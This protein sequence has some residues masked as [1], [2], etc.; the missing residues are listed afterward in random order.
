MIKLQTFGS[1]WGLP[2]PSPFVTKADV[3]LKMSGVPFEAV[4]GNLRKAPKGKMPFID[5]NGE[6]IGDTTL[7]RLYLEQKY[8]IDFDKH[9]SSTEK[10][11]AWSVEK[12]LE[13]NLYWAIVYERWMIDENARKGPRRFF[14]SIPALMR[15]LIIAMVNRSVRRNL[16]GHG[17]GRHTRDEIVTLGKRAID[18]LA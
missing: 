11:I 10:G 17:I 12:M 18:A 9:L 13:D 16:D 7:I 1:M 5:D 2:D 6:K 14:D 15:P 4:I 3:L 8:S